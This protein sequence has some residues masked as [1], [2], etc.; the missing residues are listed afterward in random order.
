M[1]LEIKTLAPDD[2]KVF[3]TIYI[4]NFIKFIINGGSA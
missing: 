4:E 2:K 3:K 1:Q